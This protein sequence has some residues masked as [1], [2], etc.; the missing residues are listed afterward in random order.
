MPQNYLEETI[1]LDSIA[2]EFNN[3]LG[4]VKATTEQVSS[5]KD[6]INLAKA[7]ALI[8]LS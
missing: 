4:P 5:E 8:G 6:I 7:P 2:G 3:T 1:A